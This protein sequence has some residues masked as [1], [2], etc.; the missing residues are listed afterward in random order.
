YDKFYPGKSWVDQDGNTINAHG[1]GILFHEGTYYWYGEKR[2]ATESL[3]INVYSSKDL[4]NWTYEGVA[5][6]QSTDEQSPIAK[7]SIME[8]PKVIYN[9]QNKQFVLYFHLELAGQVYS[10]ALSDVA[11]SDASTG[12]LEFVRLV[13]I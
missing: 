7:G 2:G 8:R 3:G 5:L 13:Y 12:A 9:K 1:G 11:V 10:A 4:Y 6:A